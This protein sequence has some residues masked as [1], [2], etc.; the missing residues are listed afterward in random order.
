MKRFL[1]LLLI[2]A[3][4]ISKA[5]VDTVCY[6]SNV[7]TYQVV[8][9]PGNTYSW[10]VASPGLIVSG[11]GTNAIV[12]N[13]GSATPGLISNGVSVFA[14]SSDGCPGPLVDLDVYVLNIT[15]SVSP[16]NLCL[17]APCVNLTGTPAGGVFSGN[18]IANGQ[19]CPT[20][21]GNSIITYTY[22]LG[23]CI[24]TATATATVNPL[25]TIS[26]ITHN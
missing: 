18:N 10:T 23:G 20:T 9:V 1:M 19:F 7:S 8:N 12:V 21:V 16:V 17:N 26:P 4:L 14:T 5:Q 24:F 13:W 3:P 15:P 2:I 25:A 11:Q 6:R 22:S